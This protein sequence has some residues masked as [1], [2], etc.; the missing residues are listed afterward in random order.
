MSALALSLMLAARPTVAV[1]IHP[2]DPTEPPSASMITLRGW[3]VR[4]LLEEGHAVAADPAGAHCVVRLRPASDGLVV[5]AQGREQRSFAV[6][7]GPDAVLRLEVLHRALLGVEQTCDASQAIAALEPGLAL[8]FVGSAEHA[9]LEAVAVVADDAGVTLT[10]W[11]RPT[12]TVA[13]V[14]RR[15]RLAEVALGPADAEC[16]LPLL[17]LDLGDGSAAAQRQA[18]SELVGAVRSASVA[19]EASAEDAGLDTRTLGGPPA[20]DP[21]PAL[22][23]LA[24]D[25][26]LVP[27]QGPPRAEMR[28]G[29]SAGVAARGRAIDPLLQAGWRMGKIRGIGGRISLSVVPSRGG[30]IRVTDSRLVVGPDWELRAGRRGHVDLALLVGT[31]LHSFTTRERTAGDVALAAELPIS[32]GVTLNRQTRLHVVLNPGMSTGRWEHHS[33]LLREAEVLWSRPWWR[34]GVGVGITHGWRIE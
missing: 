9:L 12:D 31:D 23:P 21:M 4:R 30:N 19:S 22:P 16:G 26:G 10:A 17:V 1:E 34:V 27:M 7:D 32:Y 18:A 33:G 28:L 2:P 11:P 5:E 15:G 14:E 3:L 20:G 24:E 25:E 8:R 13:C 29:I 6:E